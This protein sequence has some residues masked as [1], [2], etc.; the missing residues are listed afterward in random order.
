MSEFRYAR[1]DA[2]QRALAIFLAGASIALALLG[3]ELVGAVR[4]LERAVA[5]ER[6]ILARAAAE[7]EGPPALALYGGQ[8]AEEARARFQQDVQAIAEA[9]GLIVETMVAADLVIVDGVVRMG[10]AVSG[11]IPEGEIAEL[12]VALEAARPGLVVEELSLRRMRGRPDPGEPR[13][14]PIRIEVV[15]HADV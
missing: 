11:S 2:P 13:R 12:L 9:R 10:M 7:R 3:A 15:A 5:S 1:A 4:D 8:T 6:A 14:L